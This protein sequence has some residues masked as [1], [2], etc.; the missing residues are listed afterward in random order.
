MTYR[1]RLVV[2]AAHPAWPSWDVFTRSGSTVSFTSQLREK[3][4]GWADETLALAFPI[5]Q[6]L[7][8]R[9]DC[10]EALLRLLEPL[11]I[12]R[13]LI[14]Q[15]LSI[16]V[17][18]RAHDRATSYPGSEVD[19]RLRDGMPV[20]REGVVGFQPQIRNDLQV[21]ARKAGLLA[22]LT[23]RRFKLGLARL[24][25]SLGKTPMP[26]VAM[27]QKEELRAAEAAEAIENEARGVLLRGL[28]LAR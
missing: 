23:K 1:A 2:R 11:G 13:R 8:P 17:L 26:S 24:D 28:R 5:A 20:A 25:P 15:P 3:R 10:A 19:S 4:A 27:A 12:K 9:A 21:R 16:A 7:N 14:Q 18:F 22:R 6:V